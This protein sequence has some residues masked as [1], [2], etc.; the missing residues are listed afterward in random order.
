MCVC[1]YVCA[2]VCVCVYVCVYVCV[3]NALMVHTYGS[4]ISYE[5][6]KD[7]GSAISWQKQI[8]MM[9]LLSVVGVYLTDSLCHGWLVLASVAVG[10]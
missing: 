9:K 6:I 7:N 3:F 2:C 1:V 10:M 8:T 4:A 5:Q